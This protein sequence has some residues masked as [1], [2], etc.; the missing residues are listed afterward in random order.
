MAGPRHLLPSTLK[1]TIE[2]CQVDRRR[3]TAKVPM[4]VPDLIRL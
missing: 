3:W 1:H 2:Q 4:A